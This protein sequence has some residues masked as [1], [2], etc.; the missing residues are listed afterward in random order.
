M[1]DAFSNWPE[2]FKLSS[3]TSAKTIECFEEVIARHG[4]FDVLVT[5]NGPQLVSK[6]FQDFAAKTSFK[7]ITTAYYH[8]QSNGRAEKFVDL[9][10]TGLRKAKGSADQKLRE[11][12]HAYR[13]TPSYALDGKSPAELMLKRQM[14]SRLDL[15]RPFQ[16]PAIE[17]NTAMEGRFNFAHGAR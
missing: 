9:L 13:S 14:K 17:H 4:L 3:T 6:E 1:V 8:P 5:D 12:L 10:K 7:H 11:F 2:A 16:S 15:L